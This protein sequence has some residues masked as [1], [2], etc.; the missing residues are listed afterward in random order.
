MADYYYQMTTD[1][2][3]H[4]G[5]A[6]TDLTDGAFGLARRYFGL[7][8]DERGVVGHQRVSGALDRYRTTWQPAVNE[9]ALEIDAL[10]GATAGGAVM[11]AAADD[12]AGHLLNVQAGAAQ[13]AGSAL[14][15]PIDG[16]VAV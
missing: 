15:R 6:V 1:Q 14:S 9:V 4:S 13:A 16:S 12:D 5:R 11:V 7:I 3:H 10:G 2:V 8:D